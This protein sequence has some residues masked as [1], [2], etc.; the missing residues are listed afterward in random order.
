MVPLVFD[1]SLLVF[2]SHSL[3]VHL[4]ELTTTLMHTAHNF[5]SDYMSCLEDALG[6]D[7]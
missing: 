4:T 5:A 6:L 7:L 1:T 2:K 3:T